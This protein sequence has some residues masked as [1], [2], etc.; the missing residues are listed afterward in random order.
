MDPLKP[1]SSVI[2]G[3]ENPRVL[4]NFQRVLMTYVMKAL[5]AN[6]AHL[7]AQDNRTAREISYFQSSDAFNSKIDDCVFFFLLF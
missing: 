6:K 3:F 4:I 7:A 5:W 1:S 2:S